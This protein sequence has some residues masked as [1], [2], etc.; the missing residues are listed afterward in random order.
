MHDVLPALDLALELPAELDE[1]R[2]LAGLDPLL[3]RR[4]E[5]AAEGDVDRA[6]AQLEPLRPDERRD[7]S[8]A[9]GADASVFHLAQVSSRP[10]GTSTTTWFSPSCRS[11]TPSSSAQVTR[12]IVPWPHAVE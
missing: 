6:V 4:V 8:E 12:A 9:N 1:A 3:E 7:V 2:E 11:T 10:D 5:G